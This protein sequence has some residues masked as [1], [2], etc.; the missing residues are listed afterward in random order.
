MIS[1]MVAIVVAALPLLGAAQ[2]VAVLSSH[3]AIRTKITRA[4]KHERVRVLPGNE[5]ARAMHDEHP[6]LSDSDWARIAA[7]LGVDAFVSASVPDGGGAAQ[8]EV[9]VRSG[10]DGSIA[11]QET[12]SARFR[13]KHLRDLLAAS[14]SRRPSGFAAA[15]AAPLPT[16]QPSS[17]AAAPGAADSAAV[18]AK[19]THAEAEASPPAAAPTLAPREAGDASIGGKVSAD[20]GTTGRG[21]VL[22]RPASVLTARSQETS[23]LDGAVGRLSTFD[24]EADARELRRTFRY[25]G[26]GAAPRYLMTFNP[27]AG[28]RAAYYPLRH[29][30]VF[31]AG[32]FGAGLKTDAYPTGTRELMGGAL[33]RFPFSF[34]QIGGGASYFHHAFLVQDTTSPTDPSRLTLGI[35]NTVYSGVRVSATARVQLPGRVQLVADGAY[36]LVAKVGD[37]TAEVRSQAYFPGSPAPYGVDARAFIG[38]GLGSLFEARAGVDY[39]RYVYGGLKGTTASGTMISAS[40]A[41]DEYLAFSLGLAAVLGPR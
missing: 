34:G 26:A 37:R 8:L 2:T 29:A 11:G 7:K 4:L 38:V 33:V 9:V 41:V 23:A 19:V 24:L 28:A 18:A 25:Q 27:V 35:P 1:F 14:L 17:A 21:L 39:R 31:A 12:V 30:G 36:R 22:E 3:A 40:S 6:P 5:V 20:P 16:V 32:E 10:A 13:P 15:M